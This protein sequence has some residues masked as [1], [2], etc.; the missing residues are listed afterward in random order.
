MLIQTKYFFSIYRSESHGQVMLFLLGW[1]YS[2]IKGVKPAEWRGIWLAYDNMCQIVKSRVA[3]NDL[4]L[5]TPFNGMFKSINKIVDAYVIILKRC[6]TAIYI[7]TTFTKCI[8]S[9]VEQETL[10]RPNKH[11]F[12]WVDLRK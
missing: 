6:A 7:P 2:V 4:P 5:P 3:Q 1:L 10:K 11:L 9:Y 12:G 8:Q